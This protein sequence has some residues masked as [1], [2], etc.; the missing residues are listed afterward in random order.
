MT[1][2]G[3][4][5]RLGSMLLSHRYDITDQKGPQLERMMCTT[6]IDYIP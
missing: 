3:Q 1:L 6:T 4:D 5:E 2:P